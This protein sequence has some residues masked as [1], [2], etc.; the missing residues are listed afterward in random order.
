M[1]LLNFF[2]FF[3]ASPACAIPTQ[4]G[5]TRDLA[6]RADPNLVGY[7]GVFFLGSEP[8]VYFYLSNGNNALSFKALNKGAKILDPTLGTGGVRDPSI[9][10]GGGSEAGKKWYIIGTDLDIAKTT[11][12]AAQRKGSRSIYIWE[13][14]DLINW[15]T[16]RLVTVENSN[17][18]MVWAPDAYWDAAKGQYLVHW[19]SRFYPASD[20]NHTGT[21]SASVMRYAYTSDFKTFTTAQTLIDVSPTSIIDLSILQLGTNSYAR[22]LKNESASNVYMER[23]D[24]GL[25]GTWTRPGGSTAV[26]RTSVEGPYAYADNLVAGKVNLLLDYYGGD[27]YRPF[28]STNLNANAWVDADRTNFP[29]N[30]RHGSVIGITQARYD[31]LNAKWG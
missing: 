6:T 28:T 15:G 17:A 25:F 3:L 2:T 5:S 11:W 16:E 4:S 8:N 22:F 31:A 18:G 13:S 19:A 14:T 21:P 24:T 23:S 29:T 1:K 7:L 10:N 26:I 27:G 9:I 30:L 12:D 20:P